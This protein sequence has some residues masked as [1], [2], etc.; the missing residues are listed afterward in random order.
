MINRH[1]EFEISEFIFKVF[2]T[3]KRWICPNIEPVILCSYEANVAFRSNNI[4]YVNI[5]DILN[6]NISCIDNYEEYMLQTKR[7][8]LEVIIH[9]LYHVEQD[10]INM[11]YNMIQSYKNDIEHQVIYMT[12][13]FILKNS[14]YINQM[15]GVIVDEQTIRGKI[16]VLVNNNHCIYYNRFIDDNKSFYINILSGMIAK[17]SPMKLKD[18]TNLIRDIIKM[19][20][21][22]VIVNNVEYIVKKNYVFNNNYNELNILNKYTNST[23]LIGEIK[24]NV[25]FNGDACIIQVKDES[26]KSLFTTL[27]EGEI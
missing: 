6:R 18:L 1:I 16:D 5:D 25:L 3:F 9:E 24:T 20:D 13:I 2:E 23:S 27:K 11:K 12:L 19:R 26:L 15:F 14:Y 21:I 8:V 4:I 17:G 7:F 22:V 10:I